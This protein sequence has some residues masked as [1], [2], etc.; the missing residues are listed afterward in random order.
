[1]ST[2]VE[3]GNDHK[4]YH[5]GAPEMPVGA[6]GLQHTVEQSVSSR[7]RNVTMV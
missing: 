6:I 1:M 2:V 3:G 4:V 5:E 7:D